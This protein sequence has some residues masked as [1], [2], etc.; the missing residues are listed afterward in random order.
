MEEIFKPLVGA[1]ERYK[2]SNKGRVVNLL[3][4]KYLLPQL[5]SRDR[6]VQYHIT[7]SNGVTTTRLLS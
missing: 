1:E 2:V 7:A 4:G 5:D 6:Y 3:T